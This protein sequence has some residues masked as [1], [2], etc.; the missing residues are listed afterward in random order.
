MSERRYDPASGHWV[1]CADHR[2]DRNF[3]PSAQDCPLCPVFPV[4]R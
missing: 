3:L 4:D 1:T 2:Q